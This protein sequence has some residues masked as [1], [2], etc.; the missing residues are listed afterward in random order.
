LNDLP[1][2]QLL[3][4]CL[5]QALVV[6]M[7]APTI[8]IGAVSKHLSEHKDLQKQLR[9]NPDQIPAAVEEFVRLYT[10]YRSFARSASIPTEIAGQQV[11]KQKFLSREIAI[12]LT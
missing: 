9:E 6:A 2:L 7:I 8:F 10:P 1:C 11:S 4:G 5:R 3:S 12:L